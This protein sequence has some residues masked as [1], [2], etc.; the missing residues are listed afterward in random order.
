MVTSGACSDLDWSVVSRWAGNLLADMDD[1]M[2][3]RA[4]DDAD[5]AMIHGTRSGYRKH[6]C[7]CK[8]CLAWSAANMRAYRKRE[9][10][11]LYGGKERGRVRRMMGLGK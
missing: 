1:F 8:L 10:D 3:L 6:A 2:G 4:W 5:D 7:R 11:R 9:R